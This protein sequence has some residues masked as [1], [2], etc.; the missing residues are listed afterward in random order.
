[1]PSNEMTDPGVNFA[2]LLVQ[3]DRALFRY[4]MAFIPRH[5]DAEEV[6]Q[7]VAVV[8]WQK[9]TEYDATRDFLPWALRV[10]YFEILNFRKEAARSR[11]IFKE[12]VLEAIAETQQTFSLV[13]DAQQEALQECL[14][15]LSS[16]SEM[17]L[18]RHYCDAEAVASLAAEKGKTP[19][20]LY[21]RLDRIR[22]LVAECVERR[23]NAPGSGLIP[24]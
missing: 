9:F 7:R 16:D 20:S 6:L 21:R 8:L 4:I 18:R 19:K 24:K 22:D 11:L 17:L 1:M 14:E 10:A 13:L 15:K 23:L 5:G 12:E 3:H 2:R